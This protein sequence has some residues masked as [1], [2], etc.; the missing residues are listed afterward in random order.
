MMHVVNR[1]VYYISTIDN[2]LYHKDE[3]YYD[4]R[5]G[6]IFYTKQGSGSPILL[7]HDLNV[8]SSSY[9]WN[10]I[11]ETLSQTNTVYTIDLLGCGRSDKPNLTYT[12]YLYVQLVT[13][14]IKHIICSKTDVI[15]TGESGTFVLMACAND[16]T[17]IDKVMLVNPQNLVTLAKIPTKRTK[18]LRHFISTPIIGTF[19][20]NMLINK[21]TIE[22]SFRS[23]YYYDQNKI[24][25]RS[26]MTCFESSHKSNTRS[27]YLYASMKSRF[28]NANVMHCLKGLTNSIFII[29]GNA[30]PENGLTANQYQNQLPSIEIIG[31]DK[32]KHLPQMESPKE[33][34]DQI[35]ILFD[36]EGDI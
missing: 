36:I 26:I 3:K 21:R 8:I 17:V 25:E 14:F 15:A 12:N 20:Y 34:I 29:V 6:R 9:E 4:W 13:D 28:T 10:K 2:L 7:I 19:A 11:V 16:N 35:R 33:F 27:K 1:L 23:Q 32:T 31:I 24:E 22:D 5:F 30:N 18:L